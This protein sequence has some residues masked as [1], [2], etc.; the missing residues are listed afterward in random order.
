MSTVVFD[1]GTRRLLIQEGVEEIKR[2]RFVFEVSTLVKEV[3]IPKSVTKI[4]KGVFYGYTD[5]QH[6]YVPKEFVDYYKSMDS[7]KE[8]ADIIS[9][10]EE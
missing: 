4:E 10:Y 8:Y 9:A 1:L 6:I 3:I 5:L 7:L 2:F